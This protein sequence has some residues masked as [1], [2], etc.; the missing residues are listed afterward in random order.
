M[1]NSIPLGLWSI[2]NPGF[3]IQWPSASQ[4]RSA[5]SEEE[6]NKE[7]SMQTVQYCES[8]HSYHMIE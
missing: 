2:V 5:Y 3:A 7:E 1:K 6:N 8:N 4:L